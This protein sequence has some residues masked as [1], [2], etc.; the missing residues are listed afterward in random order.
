MD[1]ASPKR[2]ALSIYNNVCCNAV[3]KSNKFLMETLGLK[4]NLDKVLAIFTPNNILCF[5]LSFSL[6]CSIPLT[7]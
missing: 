4:Y 2:D 1:R 3:Q 6:C 5:S 7:F